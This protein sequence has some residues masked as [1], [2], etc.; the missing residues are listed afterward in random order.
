MNLQRIEKTQ[1]KRS[2][3]KNGLGHTDEIAI[4][5]PGASLA[6]GDFLWR[7]SSARIEKA[8]PFSLFPAHDRTLL[9]LKGEGIR[10]IHTFEEGEPP[11]VVDLPPLEPYEFPGDVPSKCEL[12]GGPITD[13][14]IFTRTGEVGLSHQVQEIP[15][16][17]EYAWEPHGKWNFA[18]AI[19]GSV[20]ADGEPLN[21][22]DTISVAAGPCTLR[23]TDTDATL[24]LISF[25]Q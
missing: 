10:L 9:V 23:A 7:L 19:S 4:H 3:W 13:F 25:E 24:F 14:S 22:G 20:E 15:A 18:F 17:G 6:K 21:E 12:T 8:S 2:A 5:P 1:Y 16:G 11:E